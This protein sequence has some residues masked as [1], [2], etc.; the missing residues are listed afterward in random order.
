[1]YYD[2]YKTAIRVC[3]SNEVINRYKES[4]NPVISS[5]ISA[6]NNIIKALNANK[7]ATLIKPEIHPTLSNVL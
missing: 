3:K 5:K 1:M 4:Q 2:F 7:R 6:V